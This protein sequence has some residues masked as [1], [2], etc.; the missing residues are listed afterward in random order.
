MPTIVK[1]EKPY[2][3]FQLEGD[4]IH[5]QFNMSQLKII[6]KVFKT[7]A[8]TQ[9]NLNKNKDN[10]KLEQLYSILFYDFVTQFGTFKIEDPIDNKR[11]FLERVKMVQTMTP[12]KWMDIIVEEM[13]LENPSKEEIEQYLNGNIPIRSISPLLF[14]TF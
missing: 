1:E 4:L 9:D 10:S 14:H 6:D 2:N 5:T 7:F 13:K 11:D 8:K 3:S 12:K